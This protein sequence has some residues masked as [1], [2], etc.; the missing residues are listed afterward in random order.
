MKSITRNPNHVAGPRILMTG[1]SSGIGLA[2][3]KLLAAAGAEVVMT[4]RD[5][6]R[7]TT[8]LD[9]VAAVAAGPP[10]S[11]LPADL[12][13]LSSIRDLAGRLHDR[14]DSIDVLVNNAGTASGRRVLTADGYEMTFAVNHL[15][16]FLLTQL[17]LDLLMASRAARVVNTVSETHSGRLDFDNLQGE[18]RYNFFSAY[19][20]SKT[21]NILFTY[22]LARRLE[23][24]GM[25]SN[26]FTPG[27]T[28][29]DFGRGLGGV[30]GVMG[31]LMRLIG[32]PADESARTAV[33]LATSP[34][35]EGV[36]GQYFFR[37]KPARS[38][39][40]TYDREAAARLWAI[41]EQLATAGRE[42]AQVDWNWLSLV[43][44]ADVRERK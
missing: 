10:P 11:F 18:R 1:A 37:G 29:S 34:E 24:T 17:V 15:A 8:A 32:R 27:P 42:V 31:G 25:T 43:D 6:A 35:M 39:R 21:A 19:A 36:T 14:F 23:G 41:S 5:P 13:S 44:S 12:S 33:Y 3:A 7:G 16:P 28:A 26:C 2:A 9:Q 22:E 4:S 40:I 20:R 30:V 38:K